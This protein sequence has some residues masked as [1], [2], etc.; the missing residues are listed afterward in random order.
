MLC[1]LIK[2]HIV[3]FFGWPCITIPN[4]ID[5]IV[6][7][8]NIHL[9]GTQVENQPHAELRHLHELITLGDALLLIDDLRLAQIGIGRPDPDKTRGNLRDAA[10]APDLLLGE[11][12]ILVTRLYTDIRTELEEH[13]VALHP[14]HTGLYLKGLYLFQPVPKIGNRIIHRLTCSLAHVLLLR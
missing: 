9:H 1:R 13:S 3:V 11:H 2:I 5:I 14:D 12:L 8:R 6:H 10:R 4:N 7:V